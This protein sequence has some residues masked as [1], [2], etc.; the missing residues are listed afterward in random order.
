VG[1]QFD[2]G[3]DE[4]VSAEC[5]S[6]G[7]VD[8]AEVTAEVDDL[9]VLCWKCAVREGLYD[10]SEIE[11]EGNVIDLFEDGLEE[12]VDEAMADVEGE[13]AELARAVDEGFEYFPEGS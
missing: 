13:M 12:M 5:D 8:G 11:I 9:G 10:P 1:W 4:C 3:F 6:C 7:R 2:E